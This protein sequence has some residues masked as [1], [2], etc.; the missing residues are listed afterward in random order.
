VTAPEGPVLAV[1]REYF[2]RMW[3]AH[4]FST[5][6][7]YVSPDVVYHPPRGPAKGYEGY[8]AMAE[9]F[10]KGIPDLHFEIEGA[11]EAGDTVALRLRITGTHR[12]EHL[13]VPA[14]G[15]RVEVQGRPW[16]RVKEGKVVEVWS[17]YD[18]RGMLEQMGVLSLESPA[19][20]A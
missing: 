20:K 9:R 12:G 13:G 19:R 16:L 10:V 15:R 8:R 7:A 3:N 4:D 5:F 11:V 14:T 17:L 6:D 2:E 18:E 1:V